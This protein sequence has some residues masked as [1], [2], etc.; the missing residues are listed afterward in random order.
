MDK[1]KTNRIALALSRVSFEPTE[2]GCLL[3]DGGANG[4]GYGVVSFGGKGVGAH[5]LAW[6]F[7]LDGT[8]HG[9]MPPPGIVIGHRCDVPGCCNPAHL[10]AGTKNE[11][12][13][14][15]AERGRYAW[16]EAHRSR[17]HPGR[18]TRGEAH[19]RAKL[20]DADV[21]EIFSLRAEGLLLREIAVLVG[22]CWQHVG[23]ILRG[24]SRT[25]LSPKEPA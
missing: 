19:T 3:W 12:S 17:K 20:S 14:A 8:K 7:G 22:C 15:A 13:R 24:A 11:N 1:N 4:G 16:G 18:S 25:H 9:A 10:Q 5:R 23:R 21:A 2:R 6:A